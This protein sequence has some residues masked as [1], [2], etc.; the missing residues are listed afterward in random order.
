MFL[1]FKILI[2][3]FFTRLSINREFFFVFLKKNSI[4]N[5]DISRQS[6]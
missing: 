5:I 4:L 3:L 2:F 6:K 1:L